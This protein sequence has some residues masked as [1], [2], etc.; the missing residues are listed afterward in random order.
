M[1]ITEWL[2]ILG[3]IFLLPGFLLLIHIWLD[4]HHNPFKDGFRCK[5]PKYEK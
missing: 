2:I 5:K 4:H 1:T 3:L